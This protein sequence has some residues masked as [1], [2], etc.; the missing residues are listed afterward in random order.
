[1][2]KQ[3]VNTETEKLKNVQRY[4]K[5]SD[6][7]FDQRSLI[8][9]EAW[10]PP[11]FVR[12]HQQKTNFFYAAILD[13]FVTKMFNSETTSF[14]TF[15]QGFRISKNLGHTTSGSGGK[16]GLKIYHMKRGQTNRHTHRLFNYQIESAQWADSMKI[17][18]TVDEA[19]PHRCGQ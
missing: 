8:H 17:S 5:I 7:P 14:S 12:Q 6:A 10:F 4:T 1:M 15:P 11:C 13:H 9:R 3:C 19:S 16:I 2:H 18:H